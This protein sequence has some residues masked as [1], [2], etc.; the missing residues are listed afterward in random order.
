MLLSVEHSST[1]TSVDSSDDADVGGVGV[2]EERI[3]ASRRK[4]EQC[5]VVGECLFFF[6]FS[7]SGGGLPAYI[8][9]EW[10]FFFLF[11]SFFFFL[12]WCENVWCPSHLF[13]SLTCSRLSPLT[14]A[15][16]S[17]A[18]RKEKMQ[19]HN[20]PCPSVCLSVS[21]AIQSQLRL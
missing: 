20:L 21:H 7:R 12:V 2:R 5:N 6:F 13:T 19:K 10:G 14:F 15:H 17:P 4:D 1:R 11:F 18:K 3:V 16:H 9:L 8:Y